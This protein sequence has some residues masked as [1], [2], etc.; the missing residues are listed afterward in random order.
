[1]GSCPRG[2]SDGDGGGGGGASGSSAHARAAAD[3]DDDERRRLWRASNANQ[4]ARA[5]HLNGSLCYL[6][7]V[8]EFG[9]RN[10]RNERTQPNKTRN[11]S[12]PK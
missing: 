7:A 2:F 11:L 10:K 9:A 6:I 3:D 1:M 8:A 5:T 4:I 12:A